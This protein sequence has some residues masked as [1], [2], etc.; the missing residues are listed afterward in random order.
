MRIRNIPLAAI[1]QNVKLHVQLAVKQLQR[2]SLKNYYFLGRAD[3]K[4]QHGKIKKLTASKLERKHRLA[5]LRVGKIRKLHE[6]KKFESSVPNLV[7][8]IWLN[9]IKICNYNEL[10]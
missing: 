8:C 2:I 5:Q 3:T 1:V 7:V 9:F 4:V 10:I 6:Q